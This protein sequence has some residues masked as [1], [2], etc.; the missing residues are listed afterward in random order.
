MEDVYVYATINDKLIKINKNDSMD[1]YSWRENKSKPSYWYKIKA[2]LHTD[3]KTG[4]KKY[5]LGINYKTYRLSRIVYK[6]HNNDWEIIDTSDTNFVDHINNNSLDNRIENLRVLTNQQN[7]WNNNA[8][9]YSWYKQR[10]IWT[11]QIQVN[12]KQ[13]NLGYFEN[14]EDARN[15]YLEAKSLYHIIN[16]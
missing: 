13:I 4:Y 5:V 2:T 8:K 9:G 12:G 1:I 6:A 7:Q 16:E 14:E 10:K 15:A 3:K 11:A